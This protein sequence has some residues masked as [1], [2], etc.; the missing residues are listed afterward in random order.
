[1]DT[2]AVRRPVAEKGPVPMHRSGTAGD[3]CDIGGG[4]AVAHVDA[5]G[6]C[7]PPVNR[8][9]GGE[10][11]A[12]AVFAHLLEQQEGEGG[13]SEEEEEGNG[14]KKLRLN[15]EQSAL[16]EAMFKE[17]NTLNPTQKQTLASKLNLR[18]RQVEVW[19]QNRRARTKLK[20]TEVDCEHLRKYCE[21]LADENRRLQKELHQLRALKSYVKLPAA[22]TLTMCPSCERKGSGEM[23][24]GGGGAAFVVRPKPHFC[25]PSPPP[26]PICSVLMREKE[27]EAV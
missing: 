15:K 21:R 26:I 10:G 18:P 19:F 25:S 4:G 22:T 16:L 27:G 11:G 5:V 6:G 7:L 8:W 2:D 14:K 20:Q 13:G 24:K 1:M 9:R 23:A 17:H 12:P 3:L